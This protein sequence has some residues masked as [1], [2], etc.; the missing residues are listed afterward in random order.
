MKIYV[1]KIKNKYLYRIKGQFSVKK[2]EIIS[3]FSE[4]EELKNEKPHLHG[5]SVDKMSAV[6]TKIG[7]PFFMNFL[8]PCRAFSTYLFSFFLSFS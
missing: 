4:K 2:Y 6:W 3:F 1:Q 7:K 5:V 8:S